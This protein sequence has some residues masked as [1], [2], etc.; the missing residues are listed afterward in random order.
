MTRY[1]MGINLGHERSVAIVKD[2]EIVVAIEQERLDRQKYSLGYLQQS[3]GDPTHIQLPA[4][5]IRYCLE[6]C[7]IEMSDLATITGNM[8]GRDYA[9]EILRRALPAEIAGKVQTI[10][11]HHLAHAYS[12][13]FPSGFD[14]A[15]VL[16]VDATGT[17]TPDHRTESYTLY[18]GRKHSLSTLHS[19]TVVAHL[20]GLSTLGFLYEYITR[21][22]GFTSVV[23][24][25]L[26]H[27]EAGKL[28]GLAPF[29]QAQPNLQRWVHT[30]EDS[31]SLKISA[32][33]IFLE[34][35]ALEKYYDD[36][37]GKAYLRPY[38]VDLA[39]K[40]QQELEQ[41]LLHIVGLAVKQTGLRKLCIAGGVGL[42]SVAN[43]QLL[44]KLELE[45]IFIFPAAGDS[46]IAAGCGLWAY[47]TI[48]CGQTRVPLKK[49]TLGRT[50]RNDEVMQALRHFSA[51]IEIEQLS[52]EEMVNRSAKALASGSIIARFEGGSEYGPRALGHRSILADPSFRRMKDIVNARVKFREAFRPFAP[53]IPLEAVSEVFEQPVAAPFMLL[54]SDIKP[55]FHDQIPAVTHVDG[56]G[57]VQTVTEIENPF[58]YRLCHQLVAERESVPV[59]LNT[60]FN[61]AGQ[62]IVE[63]PF[64]AISTF[65]KTDI[66]LLAI[67]NFWITKRNVPVLSYKA[68]LD[69]VGDSPLPCG[70]PHPIPEMYEMMASLDRALFFG[71]VS[72][73]P[74]S[75]EELQKLST[76]G[77]RFKETSLLFPKAP[78]SETPHTKLSETIVLILDPLGQSTIADLTRQNSPRTYSFEEVKLLLTVLKSSTESLDQ[79]RIESQLTT[80]EFSDRV[81]WAEQQLEYYGLKPQ[82]CYFQS[83]PQDQDLEI[84]CTQT[85][86]PFADETFTLWQI[87]GTLRDRLKQLDYTAK[88]IC[89][90]LNVPSQQHIEPTHLHYYDRYCLPHNQL[91]DVIRLFL[92]RG[93]ISEFCLKQIFGAELFSTLCDLGVLI[94]RDTAWASRIDLFDVDGLYIATDH[95]YLILPEDQIDEDP[96]MY[97]GLDSMGLVHTA[98]RECVDR[99]LD[100]CCGGGVQGL[101][102]SRYAKS[103]TSVDINPRAIRYARFNAQVNHIRNIEFRLG[104]LY[105]PVKGH[106][107]TILANPPFVPSPSREMW[108]RDGGDTGEDILSEIIEKSADYLVQQGRLF[109]V[110]DLVNLPAYESKLKQWWRGGAAHQ[111]VLSTADRNDILFSVPHCH[112]AFNQSYAEYKSELD[113]WL[114]NF[115]HA[116][117]TAVNFGYI[118]IQ[119]A[120]PQS[121]GSYYTRTIHNPT[122]PIY[123]NVR[124][125]FQQRDRLNLS[126][127]LQDHLTLSSDLHFRFETDLCTG[128]TQIELFS[129][130][131]PYYTTYPINEMLYSLLNDIRQFQPKWSAYA[132]PSNQACLNDLICKGILHLTPT[133]AKPDQT[134]SF[135]PSLR[136]RTTG[137]LEPQ[138]KLPSQQ[139]H[140]QPLQQ[141]DSPADLWKIRELETKTTP[142]CLSSYLG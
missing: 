2:G 93:A 114:Y 84:D 43:Y 104:S 35:A 112:A 90:L 99:V 72:N 107:D 8:P 38:L 121:I 138:P 31:F 63:T 69:Q 19:E 44:Q 95:R 71:D 37:K 125:Y 116:R 34:V 11:S 56:T 20:A 7:G 18:K 57:R 74:W 134:P 81:S 26:T 48:E 96:V 98:P 133:I 40:V 58:L 1:H 122:R 16:V 136:P 115:H 111:L 129:P 124:Q 101:V 141:A 142:T 33:D 105:Q 85:L 82:H 47:S 22:A 6:T 9:P 10:P 78:F 89:Q 67:K 94:Q 132:T 41:A 36:G 28:M 128:V 53:V 52:S 70:L 86:A 139:A 46:G 55:E 137:V 75:I 4:E 117:L 108:F 25:S 119:R 3:P 79:I 30:I 61:V 39:Y 123:Q 13:Y 68:H 113:Q 130:D 87:L 5:A 17:T 103:V 97:V 120:L 60:S 29:G 109:I 73:C 102:A 64:D 131:N 88:T 54:I 12:A 77:G 65:L 110:T 51:A 45:D 49:A 127:T 100:L 50:Y 83:L 62:P 32:Y 24:E 106:F 21:K 14:Q 15:L 92:L 27:A 76:Q 42:N 23:S 118:L 66:D 140:D 91:G 135:S 59:L 126:Y 80:R